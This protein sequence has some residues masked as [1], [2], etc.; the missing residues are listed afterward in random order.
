MSTAKRWTVEIM[1]D[2]ADDGSTHVVARLDTNDDLHLHG[3]GTWRGPLDAAPA[4]D[5][6][7]TLVGDGPAVAAALREVAAKLS[8]RASLHTGGAR[9]AVGEA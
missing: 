9:V 4:E 5:A 6:R 7:A 8:A 2:E 3:H 1:I